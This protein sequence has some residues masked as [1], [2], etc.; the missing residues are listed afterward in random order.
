MTA[1]SQEA[2]MQALHDPE[3]QPSQYGT[4]PMEWLDKP[5]LSDDECDAL[6]RHMAALLD[7]VAVALR[8]APAPRCRWSWHDLPDRVA[9]VMAALEGAMSLAA[10][11]Q[12]G[13]DAS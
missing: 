4:V 5:T 9:A 2:L 11:Q 3:N 1:I 13:E 8:G 7:G 10:T 6:R 12:A